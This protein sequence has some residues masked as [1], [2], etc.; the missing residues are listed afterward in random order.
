MARFPGLDLDSGSVVFVFWGLLCQECVHSME[1]S[2]IINDYDVQG[3]LEYT[4]ACARISLELV[5]PYF[6]SRER[7]HEIQIPGSV[8]LFQL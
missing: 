3:W 1:R 4:H 2:R 5:F 6:L 8:H 7:R